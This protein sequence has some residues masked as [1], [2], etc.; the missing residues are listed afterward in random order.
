MLKFACGAFFA[1]FIYMVISV[2]SYANTSPEAALPMDASRQPGWRQV[3]PILDIFEEI[4]ATTQGIE[5]SSHTRYIALTF[6]DGPH[7]VNTPRILDAL[8]RYEARATFYVL[9]SEVVRFP[10]I[11]QRMQDEGH[12]VGNHTFNHTQLNRRNVT[13]EIALWQLEETNRVIE[14]ITGVRVAT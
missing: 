13:E 2:T 10:H 4:E 11:I 6:D 3:R 8:A 5:P 1:V 9:G 7:G 12:L 14:E